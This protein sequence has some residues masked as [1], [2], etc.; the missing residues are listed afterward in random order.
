MSIDRFDNLARTLAYGSSRRQL[1]KGFAAGL[2][3][4][5]FT[6][7]GVGRGT[8]PIVQAAATAEGLTYLP[9]IRSTNVVHMCPT[10]STCNEKVY[11]SETEDCRC[12]MSAEGE[13]RCGTVPSCDID[14]C[15]TSAD[16]AHLGEGYFCDTPFSGCCNDNEEQRCIAPCESSPTCPAELVCGDECCAEGQT[17]RDGACVD[18][19][20]GTWSGIATYEGQSIGIRFILE[21]SGGILTG[22]LLMQDPVSQEYLETGIIEGQRFSDNQASWTTE[23]GSVVDGSFDQESFTGTYTFADFHEEIGITA[24]LTLERTAL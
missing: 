7:F 6:T 14:R 2:T 23:A 11:C 10:A 8:A 19:T 20:A 3:A 15:T 5:I 17:C 24:D 9:L 22:R 16:C 21:Q 4:S 13:L 18:A 1:L 12:I